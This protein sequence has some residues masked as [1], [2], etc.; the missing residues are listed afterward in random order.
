MQEEEEFLVEEP[1]V[2]ESY[3]QIEK[4]PTLEESEK[5]PTYS[6]GIPSVVEGLPNRGSTVSPYQKFYEASRTTEVH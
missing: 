6:E 1:E 3:Y 4:P 5:R 2:E